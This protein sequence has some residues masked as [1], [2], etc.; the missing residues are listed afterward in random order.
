MLP[1]FFKAATSCVL[2]LFLL[3]QAV[4]VLN[5]VGQKVKLSTSTA[6]DLHKQIKPFVDSADEG[7]AASMWCVRKMG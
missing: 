6:I 7:G 3:S 2:M 5:M 1:L 4:S